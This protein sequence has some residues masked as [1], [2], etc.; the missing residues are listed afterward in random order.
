MDP[1][2]VLDP[3]VLTAALGLLDPG[4]RALLD[5]SLRWGVEDAR[6]A[7]LLRTDE[8]GVARRRAGVVEQVAAHMGVDPLL[9]AGGLRNALARLPPPAWGVP[10]PESAR[11]AVQ[12]D[13]EQEPPSP[14]TRLPAPVVGLVPQADAPLAPNRDVSRHVL[15]AVRRGARAMLT[16]AV[17]A[18]IGAALGRRWR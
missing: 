16:L 13:D 4:S 14:V 5:L 18:V 17:G 2:A 9:G 6:I 3:G 15:P 7:R 11:R 12:P 10:V 1:H 8:R